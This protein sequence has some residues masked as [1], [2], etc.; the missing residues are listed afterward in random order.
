MPYPRVSIGTSIATFRFVTSSYSPSTSLTQKKI[1][2]PEGACVP[3]RCCSRAT[4]PLYRC[5]T[6]PQ[7]VKPVPQ[8]SHPRSYVRSP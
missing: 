8:K 5:A 1:L 7:D 3:S 6:A 4:V 2:T